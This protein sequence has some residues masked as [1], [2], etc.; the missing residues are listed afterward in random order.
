MSE[1]YTIDKDLKEAE[2]MAKALVPYVHEGQ[3]YGNV[4]G[5][6]IFGSGNM[7]S[8]TIGAF[9]MRLRRLNTFSLDS[10]QKAR[11]QKAEHR[12]EQVLKEWRVHYERKLVREAHSRLDAMRTFFEE[13]AADPALCARVYGPEVLRRTT[14]QEIIIAMEEIGLTDDEL[15]KKAAGVDGRLRRYLQASDFVWDEQLIP[16]YPEKPFWWM[17]QHPPTP[18]Q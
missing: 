18:G 12:N 5:G 17:Y 10:D 13:C 14:V 2:A 11:L 9:L 6:G 15:T 3:L 16:A 4:G 1:Q 8:L 7:P